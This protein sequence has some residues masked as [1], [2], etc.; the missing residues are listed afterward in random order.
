M[1]EREYIVSL[2]KGIDYDQFWDQIE[3]NSVDDGFVPTRRVDIVNNRDGSL[4]SCHY[5]LTDDEAELLRSDPRVYSVE[6]PPDQR[7]DVRIGF[8]AQQAGFF[9]K[10]YDDNGIHANWGLVRCNYAED[11]YSPTN[12]LGPSMYNYTLDGTGVD[13]VIQDSGLQIDHPEFTDSEGNSRVQ[14][15]NWYSA[16]G[17]SGTQSIYH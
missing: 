1:A 15:I 10:T 6:I 11:P 8:R 5:A 14:L 3:N 12:T 4:R 2:N 17:L 16:S 9:R 13:V 7:R